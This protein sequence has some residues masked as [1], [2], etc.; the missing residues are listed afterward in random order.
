[1]TRSWL[2]AEAVKPAAT[3]TMTVEITNKIRFAERPD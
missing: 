2:A 1:V 3:E